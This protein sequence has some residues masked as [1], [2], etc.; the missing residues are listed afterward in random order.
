[1]NRV[2]VLAILIQA[3]GP[4]FHK[5]CEDVDFTTE[6]GICVTTNGFS[7]DK[8]ELQNIVDEAYF[9][10][11]EVYPQDIENIEKRIRE[12]GAEIVFMASLMDNNRGTTILNS[13]YVKWESICLGNTAL[14]HELLHLF[15]HLAKRGGDKEHSDYRLFLTGDTRFQLY[16]SAENKINTEVCE[17][18]CADCKWLVVLHNWCWQDNSCPENW[19]DAC[20]DK[21]AS[22]QECYE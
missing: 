10:Y 3:C 19:R 15:R 22:G 17:K 5:V 9:R 11:L 18:V 13:A 1:M 7:I 2:V 14:G 16:T 8:G 6:N 21:M 12:R 20:W 4:E